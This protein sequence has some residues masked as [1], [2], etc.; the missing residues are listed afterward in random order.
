MAAEL[1]VVLNKETL[2]L[3]YT[4]RPANA[5]WQPYVDDRAFHQRAEISKNPELKTLLSVGGWSHND[6]PMAW[7]FTTMVETP[8]S[9]SQFPIQNAFALTVHKTQCLTLPH[10]S[11]TVDEN[12]FAAGQVYRHR[13]EVEPQIFDRALADELR[14]AAGVALVDPHRARRERIA[15]PLPA[16][17]REAQH[18]VGA[19]RRL[20][21]I[22]VRAGEGHGGARLG[23]VGGHVEVDVPEGRCRDGGK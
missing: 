14:I 18:G 11:L 15:E 17:G 19:D 3:F 20:G 5:F 6:P 16:R 13:K 7:L 4:D 10:T 9:R 23:T 22:G 21:R 12:M 8:A 1:G 2:I